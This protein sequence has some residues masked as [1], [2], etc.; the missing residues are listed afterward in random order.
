MNCLNYEMGEANYH[1]GQIAIGYEL[2]E[3]NTFRMN[4][5]PINCLAINGPITLRLSYFRVQ[6]Y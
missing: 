1:K 5:Q 6:Q 2:F 4:Y 3:M